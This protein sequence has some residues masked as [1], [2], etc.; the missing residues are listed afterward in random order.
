MQEL[1]NEL[2]QKAGLTEESAKK[3]IETTMGFIKSKLPPMFG[4]KID[5]IVNGKFDLS[6]MFGGG[7]KG[8]NDS[9]L[10]KLKDMF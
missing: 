7:S 1:I 10:D 6:S 2:M 5:D 8:D 3:A 9:P 4:D